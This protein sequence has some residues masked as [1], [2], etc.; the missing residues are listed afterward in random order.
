MT[1]RSSEAD[2]QLYVRAIDILYGKARG[3]WWPKIRALALRG[4]V[5][6]MIELAD[7]L[8]DD[9]EQAGAAANPFS[10]AGLYRRAYR[11]GEP[12]AA[13]NL[14]M[15]CFNRN[16][17]TGYRT[18][19]RKAGSAGDNAARAEAAR[20]ET[21]LPHRNAARIGRHR[22]HQRRDEFA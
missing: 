14:A 4:H 17:L 18:W 9:D 21:R 8:A 2:D 5:D 12:R 19:M 15:T 7:W 20:F 3:L 6:A 22:P 10:A 11:K 13:H 1:K 16:D